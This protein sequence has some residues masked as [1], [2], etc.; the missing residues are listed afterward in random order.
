M[1]MTRFVPLALTVCLVLLALAQA[2]FAAP[3]SYPMVC[4]GGGDMEARFSHVKASGGFH[5]TSLAITFKKSRAAASTSEPAPGHC[6][7]L[8]RPI[9]GDEPSSL[10]YAPGASQDFSFTFKGERW[11]LGD[12]EDD[13]LEYILTKMRRG[14]LF[15][16]RCHREVG[17]LRVD[18]VGP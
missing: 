17:F 2:S 13:G 12:T 1:S 6:A 3:K 14:E 4:K 9:A 5:S 8:D 7:W 11:T 18:Q 10:A 15:Y 16:V